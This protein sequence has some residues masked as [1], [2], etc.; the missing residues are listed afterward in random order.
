[1]E[2]LIDRR[3]CVFGGA[4]YEWRTKTGLNVSSPCESLNCPNAEMLS[5]S[6][7]RM[8]MAAEPQ[9]ST[10]SLRFCKRAVDTSEGRGK[11]SLCGYFSESIS[12]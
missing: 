12:F 11:G 4:D 3:V 6:S 7:L 5:S 2:G 1:M 8:N 9:P 10:N